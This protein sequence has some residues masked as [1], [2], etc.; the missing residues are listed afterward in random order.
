MAAQYYVFSFSKRTG[1]GRQ[2]RFQLLRARI[3]SG[4]FIP[5]AEKASAKLWMFSES[6]YAG[7]SIGIADF[8]DRHYR[9][10]VRG[11]GA[12]KVSAGGMLRPLLA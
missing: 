8:F 9:Q 2:R 4:T 12:S 11:C 5:G 6:S 7:D 1:V 10:K 3:Q